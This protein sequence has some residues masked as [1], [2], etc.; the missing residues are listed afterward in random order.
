MELLGE[1]CKMVAR[2]ESERV[3]LAKEMW[4]IFA[5]SQFRVPGDTLCAREDPSESP[6]ELVRIDSI[7]DPDYDGDDEVWITQADAD[8]GRLAAAKC[9]GRVIAADPNGTL[10]DEKALAMFDAIAPRKETG[11]ASSDARASTDW[12]PVVVLVE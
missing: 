6:A 8:A 5:C 12:V 9:L 4:R 3:A 2:T 1:R 11:R 10:P 7:L